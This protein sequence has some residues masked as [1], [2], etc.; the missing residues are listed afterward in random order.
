ME[1]ERAGQARRLNKKKMARHNAHYKELE[2]FSKQE[3]S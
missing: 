1:E 3:H 2:H